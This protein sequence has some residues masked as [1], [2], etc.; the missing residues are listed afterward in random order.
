MNRP[1]LTVEHITRQFQIDGEPLVAL[2]DINLD[3]AE[4][5]FVTIVGA[6]GCGKSTLLRLFAGLDV[7]TS[8]TI[9]HAGEA[10]NEPSLDRGI[11]FQEPRL[12]PWL[13]V[14]KN[15]S[16][17]LLNS[18][19]PKAQKSE[20]VR[21]HLEL[22][23]LSRFANVYPYQLSGGMAQRAGIARG[24]VS[25]PNVLLLD[26]PFGA[27]DAI[28][29]AHLQDE[30]EEIWAKENITMVMVTHDVEEA[31]Y[32]GDRVVVMSPRPGRIREIIPVRLARPRRRTSSEI[33]SARDRVLKSLHATGENTQSQAKGSKP[34]DDGGR[35][36]RTVALAR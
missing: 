36:E 27:L 23:G 17:G 14:E 8:G 22:V 18:R 4:G 3:I 10:V 9:R 16:L 2:D 7:A 31:V 19:L 12:F 29:K 26:E 20:L 33:A 5:E 35:T 15:V 11:V 24:L 6:S 30:L 13:T 25:R 34:S 21:D 28:T 1:H 32:L